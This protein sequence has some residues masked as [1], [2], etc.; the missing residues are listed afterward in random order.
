M[1]SIPRVNFHKQISYIHRPVRSPRER[2][3]NQIFILC[4]FMLQGKNHADRKNK[5]FCY[6]F[7]YDIFICA[8]F[9]E[10]KDPPRR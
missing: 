3:Q 10:R 8:L 7:E 4:S 1:F 9:P 6:K 5:L 2:K